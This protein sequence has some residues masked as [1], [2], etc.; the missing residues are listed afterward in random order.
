MTTASLPAPPEPAFSSLGYLGVSSE[1]LEDW[2]SFATGRLG[3]QA[4]E[5]SAST[6]ALRMDERRARLIVTD[7]GARGFF[8]WEVAERDRFDAIA[9][10]LDAAGIGVHELSAGECALRAVTAGLSFRDPAG[11]RVEVAWGPVVDDEPF[12]PGRTHS[13]FRTGSLGL[14]H[15]VLTTP[16]YDALVAFY[17]DVLGFRLSDYT[18]QPFRAT[19]LRLNARHHS[20]AII[21]TDRV[22]VHHVMVE[23]NH[24]DDVGQAYDLALAEPD[25][26][27]VTLGRHSNDH[28]FS[29]YTR[30]PSDFLIEYGWGGRSVDDRTWQPCELLDGPSLWGHERFWL[31]PEARR[32][33]Y[34][35][36]VAAAQRGVRAPVH[37]RPGNH[38]VAEDAL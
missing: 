10:A 7:D 17:V 15:A 11:N 23:L 22:G 25:S 3:M 36:Q 13:G 34:D 20:L 24:M 2:T 30:T 16:A 18:T 5:R 29:F 6:R 12:R 33:A 32:V 38:D 27:G 14:G 31:P 26:I 8:G 1:R 19:F 28:M 9:D 35:L 4:G 37:V 21:E